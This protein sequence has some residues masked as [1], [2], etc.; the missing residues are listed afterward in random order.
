MPQTLSRDEFLALQAMLLERADADMLDELGQRILRDCHFEI[1]RTHY[2]LDEYEEAILAYSAA[3][4]RYPHD[5]HVLL[6]YVQM[7]ACYDRLGKTVE[8]MRDICIARY[9]AFGTAGNAPKIKPISLEKMFQRYAAG[10][11]D[12][13]VN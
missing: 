5:P 3:A 11:L 2:A 8:A 1:A 13:R 7:A 6:A 12:P 4:H 10:E 9:E